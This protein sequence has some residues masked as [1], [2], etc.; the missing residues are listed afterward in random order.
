[1]GRETQWLK[2]TIVPEA[3]V[4]PQG[5]VQVDPGLQCAQIVGLEGN[6]LVL[7][8]GQRLEQAALGWLT[9]AGEEMKVKMS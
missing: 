7:L 3:T 6:G 8:L 5:T 9:P 1:M 4:R 2:R